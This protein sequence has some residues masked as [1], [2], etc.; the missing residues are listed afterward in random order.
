[1]GTRWE[2]ADVPVPRLTQGGANL[3]RP[4][5]KCDPSRPTM[6]WGL[7]GLR[8]RPALRRTKGVVTQPRMRWDPAPPIA[9]V[10][11]ANGG[12]P[13]SMQAVATQ[14]QPDGMEETAV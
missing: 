14:A 7:G 10:P 8:P 4:V 6:M 9:R 11:Q 13:A 1:M 12:Q 2:E 5:G 3:T